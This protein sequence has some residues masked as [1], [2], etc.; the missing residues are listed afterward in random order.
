MVKT[1]RRPYS[2]I[3]RRSTC[4]KIMHSGGNTLGKWEGERFGIEEARIVKVAGSH[5]SVRGQVSLDHKLQGKRLEGSQV[6]R[7]LNIRMSKGEVPEWRI[8]V[9][10]KRI[11]VSRSSISEDIQYEE[12]RSWYLKSLESG[13]PKEILTVN[14]R[15]TSVSGLSTMEYWCTEE[16]R[17]WELKLPKPR[18]RNQL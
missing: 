17:V 7:N 1:Q 15:G 4:Q 16:I 14:L 13:D 11:D 2:L 6:R 10:L 3:T 8:V 12:M 9:G 5:R 18:S